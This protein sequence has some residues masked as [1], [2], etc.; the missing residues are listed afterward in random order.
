APGVLANDTDADGDPLT[1]TLVTGPAHGTLT[2]SANGSFTFTP[3]ANYN[4]TDS[5]TYT[6]SDGRL[7]SSPATVSLT[8]APANDPP[9]ANPDS[10]SGSDATTLTVSATNGVLANDTDIDGDSLTATLVTGPAHGSLSL[11]AD[12][13]FTYTPAANYN[14]SDSFTYTASDGI[15]T[16]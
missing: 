10:Y 2:L 16:S 15:A 11:N 12:G 14:G 4:G 3:A 9:V 7:T 1:A 8:I 6:A 13:S 5:F